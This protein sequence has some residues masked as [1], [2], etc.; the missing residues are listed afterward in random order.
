[1]CNQ[2]QKRCGEKRKSRIGARAKE[3]WRAGPRSAYIYVESWYWYLH[4]KKAVLGER[5]EGLKRSL[6]TFATTPGLLTTV[7]D[8]VCI[9]GRYEH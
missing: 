2:S 9:G 6:T 8:M 5:L 1:M 7:D 3:D 4:V